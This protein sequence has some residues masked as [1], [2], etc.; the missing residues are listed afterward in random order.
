MSSIENMKVA[1]VFE[2]Y[3]KHIQQKMWF[4][5]DLILDTAAE[6]EGV[7]TVEETL[8]WGE[9]S[10]L[11]KNGSAIR[12][13]WKKSNPHQYAIYFN[14]HTMLVDTFKELFRDK[15]KFEGN[16][17]IVFEENDEIPVDELKQCISSSLTYHTR[18]HLPMLGI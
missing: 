14:C 15:F 11:T 7:G 18:K 5:R 17:A 12:I 16:R 10:Y 3:P 2:H 1:A 9:P 13:N 6:T 8:K 4:L